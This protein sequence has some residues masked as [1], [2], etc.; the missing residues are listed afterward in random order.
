MTFHYFYAKRVGVNSARNLGLKYAKSRFI[1]FLDDDV[2]LQ[3][4]DQIE[5]IIK[6]ALENPNVGIIGGGY[7]LPPNTQTIDNAYHAIANSWQTTRQY[8]HND[9]I[10]FLGG[11]TLY[12]IEAINDKLHFNEDIIFGGSETELNLRLTLKKVS[13]IFSEKLNITHNTKINFFAFIKKGYLQGFGR[14][15]HDLISPLT[16]CHFNTDSHLTQ[17]RNLDYSFE[18]L[19]FFIYNFSFEVGY[20]KGKNKLEKIGTSNLALIILKTFSLYDLMYYLFPD[21]RPYHLKPL[22]SLRFI[23][24]YHWLKAHVFWRFTH[25]IPLKLFIIITFWSTFL[26]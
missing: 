23:E 2:V 17:T 26:Q 16:N 22:P 24:I 5:N 18:K 13:V 4:E 3:N 14:S 9:F 21:D 10:Q 6:I 12:N 7:L 25:R 19:L 8:Q 11:N 1:Y 15:Y 20:R